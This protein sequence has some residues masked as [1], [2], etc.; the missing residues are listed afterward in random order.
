MEY[1]I[2]GITSYLMGS[3]PFGFI[4]TK[5][6]LKKDIR[7]IGSGNIGATNALRTGNKLVGYSTL[8]L[9]IVKAIIP[10]I[11]VKINYPELIYIASLCAFLGHV[12]PIWLKFN[13]G[14][15]VAT[16]VGILFSI[17]I[18]LGFIFVIS[19]SVI[20]LISRYSSLSSIIGSLSVPLYLFITT[21]KS[22]VIFFITM[23]V[24]I[25]FTHRENIIRLKNKE[26]SKTKIY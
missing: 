9:D 26:E 3:I 18:L 20:F 24:L 22:S 17:N 2:V 21:E 11:Y 14:K 13:G 8:I 1:L 12:F 23:F 10:V 16:Y 25:F 7:E 15:G 5:I 19:W 6:F 4:L